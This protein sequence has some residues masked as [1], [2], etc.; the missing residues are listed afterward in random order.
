M[1]ILTNIT[2]FEEPSM[3]LEVYRFW[4]LFIDER[5]L[6]IIIIIGESKRMLIKK[7]KTNLK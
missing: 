7:N 2:I 5:P 4:P 3:Y 6:I 1:N